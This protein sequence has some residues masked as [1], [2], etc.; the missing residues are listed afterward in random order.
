MPYLCPHH[1]RAVIAMFGLAV[2]S[3][4]APGLPEPTV[5]TV[6]FAGQTYLIHQA[7]N[8]W[9]VQTDGTPVTCR[10]ATEEDCYWSL[11]HWLNAQDLLDDL[12]AK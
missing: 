5:G 11:R 6:S 7:G 1:P 8:G 9:Q 10:K 3:G 12:D 4:C 2:L